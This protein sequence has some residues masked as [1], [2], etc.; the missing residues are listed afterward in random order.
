MRKNGLWWCVTVCMV[1]LIIV[2]AF[3]QDQSS[4][5]VTIY[6]IGRSSSLVMACIGL[7][8]PLP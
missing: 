3:G 2:P 4:G 6:Q 7:A 5:G 8:K 1:A